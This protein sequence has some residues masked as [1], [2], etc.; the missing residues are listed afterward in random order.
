MTAGRATTIQIGVAPAGSGATTVD[1][2]A[3]PDP[4][5]PAVSP[6][7][8]TLA[9]APAATGADHG[10]RCGV[11]KPATAPISVTAPATTGSY[12]LRLNLRTSSGVTLPPVVVDIEVQR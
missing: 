9:V 12:P 7:S 5:G 11:P 4:G 6:S 8:G 3:V 2:Q 10:V 1:W